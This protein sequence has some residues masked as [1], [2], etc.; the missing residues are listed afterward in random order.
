MAGGWPSS[1]AQASEPGVLPEG[2]GYSSLIPGH[3]SL[4]AGAPSAHLPG[5]LL[6]DGAGSPTLTS[7]WMQW[8]TGGG[9]T[10]SRECLRPL[11]PH[12]VRKGCDSGQPG[13]GNIEDAD[14]R[15]APSA[16][17]SHAPGGESQDS[18]M[19]QTR[20]GG[21]RHWSPHEGTQKTGGCSRA[22]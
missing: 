21:T 7:T 5:A 22:S 20:N 13:T 11:S 15:A 3:L 14:G 18:S 2:Q 9:R 6:I 17:G 12:R 1:L 4:G 10:I 16:G 8:G 19:E